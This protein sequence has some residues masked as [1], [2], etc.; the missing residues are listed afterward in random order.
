M[1]GPVVERPMISDTFILT[2]STDGADPTIERIEGVDNAYG[3]KF[4]LWTQY[5]DM[6]VEVKRYKP[7]Q[8]VR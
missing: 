6:T 7:P 4:A 1:R 2:Y 8:G 5:P 3:R